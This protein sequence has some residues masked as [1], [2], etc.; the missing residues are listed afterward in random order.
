MISIIV[1]I[2]KNLAIGKNNDLLWHL[3]DDLKRFKRIT[4]GHKVIMGRNTYL[5]LPFRPLKERENIVISDK[6]EEVFQGCT[7]VRSIAEAVTLCSSQEECFVIGGASVYT[8][9][10]PYADKLYITWVHKDFEGDVFFP[11]INFEEWN[12]I[13]E[14]NC[15]VDENLGFSWSYTI[16]E[17][18]R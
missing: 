11:G 2:A 1:A 17:R 16:Y 3:P 8:Q 10:L 6:P 18:I 7:M 12:L 13:S 14:E 5:S 9:F 4:L 15:P